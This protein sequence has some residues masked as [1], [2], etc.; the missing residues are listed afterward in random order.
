MAEINKTSDAKKGGLFV[1]KSHK[2]GGIPAIVVD[3]GQPIEVEGGEAII[4]KEATAK[5]WKELSE[6]N[7]SAGN[8]VPI[9]P[10]HSVPDA[11]EKYKNGGTLSVSEKKEIYDRWKVLV[12]MTY[13]ELRRYYHTK[14]GK[15]SGLTK[16]E[17]SEQG[18]SSGRESAEWI[19]KMKK[20]N[21]KKWTP[22]MWKW[23]SKQI[24]FISRMS[25][26][27]GDLYDEKKRKTPKHKALLIWGHNPRKK[28][29]HGG[30]LAPKGDT[31]KDRNW[32][33]RFHLGAGKDFM[34]WKVENTDSKSIKFLEP[35][36][37]QIRMTNCKLTNSPTTAKKIFSGEINKSPIAWVNCQKVEV[38]EEIDQVDF[39]ERI[40]YN[41]RKSPYWMDAE[42]NIV[43]NYV[44]DHLITYGRSVYYD[45]GKEIYEIGGFVEQEFE[46]GGSVEDNVEMVSTEYLNSIRTQDQSKWNYDL[47]KS[48]EAEGVLEPVVISYY[49]EEN[50]VAL[51]DGHHR[52]DTAIDLDIDK[53]PAKLVLQ[54]DDPTGKVKVKDAP[55]FNPSASK[56]SDIAIYDKGGIAGLKALLPF[57][58]GEEKSEL[59]KE[60]ARLEAE[61]KK[62]KS[63]PL[64]QTAEV[65]NMIDQLNK[66]YLHQTEVILGASSTDEQRKLLLEWILDPSQNV[67]VIIAFSG[68]KDSV[69]LVL[70]A[71]YEF[72]I[73]KN[74]IE[75]W[76]HEVDGMGE[77]VWDWQC[78][79]SYCKAFAKAMG[80]PILF[81][82]ADGGITKEIYK[83]NGFLQPVFFQEEQDGEFK[84]V[85]PR[86]WESDRGTKRKFPAVN[87]SLLTRWCSS[88]VKVDVMGK[89][90][91][92][93][94][95]FD[96][97]NIV[98]MTGE[99]RAESTNRAKYDEIEKYRNYTKTRKAITWR[100]VIDLTEK[101]VWDLYEKHKIQPHPCYELGWGRCSCQICIF[102]QKDTWASVNELDPRKVQRIAT[103]E[104]EIGNTLYAKRVKGEVVT[105]NIYDA[106][107]NKGKSFIDPAILKRWGKEAL[108][109]F[110]S[111][112]FVDKWKLPKGA[113]SEEQSGAN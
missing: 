7:Q 28:M 10:P 78:T 91:N 39:E 107:V 47:E 3:T 59:E 108:G 68:G 23:A 62:P 80:V 110:V 16:S 83:E 4:N 19:M 113:F 57:V 82:Y 25:G 66:K 9:P 31:N 13:S 79:P 43:D 101:D 71:I 51:T 60:I 67:K 36:K 5:H 1:G 33:I 96:N 81:S 37:V 88:V 52:L 70:R 106:M 35:D 44:F 69:A 99:R 55:S 42:G 2:E 27:D 65:D 40:S 74:Q 11:E 24:S 77:N 26:V 103:I 8:G 76:H 54:Y 102:N 85:D 41:P 98:I 89:A 93:S 49:P 112:I 53:I 64:P 32:K 63:K 20:V 34:K 109:E 111:P 72:K 15:E 58:T 61:E 86:G 48:I 18:I 14:D 56:P 92:N 104:K 94:P 45:D 22:E 6:I 73:P 100:S 97:A 46:T 30:Q 90:I 17:A 21:W 95:R 12:N 87:S 50:K 75:L 29:K 84:R 105:E 38:S